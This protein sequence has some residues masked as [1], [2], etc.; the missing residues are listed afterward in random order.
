MSSRQGQ[1]QLKAKVMLSS[2]LNVAPGTHSLEVGEGRWSEH[3]ISLAPHQPFFP[4]HSQAHSS[5]VC[6]PATLTTLRPQGQSHICRSGQMW[7]G[8]WGYTH[9]HTHTHTH[10]HTHIPTHVLP[11]HQ[12]ERP[13]ETTEAL[14]GGGQP[15]P[16]CK[17]RVAAR[18]QQPAS[19]V[20]SPGNTQQGPRLT[21]ELSA[22]RQGWLGLWHSDR[23]AKKWTGFNLLLPAAPGL[24]EPDASPP[25]QGRARVQALL[26]PSR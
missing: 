11:Q 21:G 15:C 16:E 9:T 4:Q 20:P 18:S 23:S 5:V 12:E 19:G 1:G 10:A 7:P 25:V 3:R 14:S 24:R 17:S 22:P 13:W 2:W 6:P 8:G 26:A